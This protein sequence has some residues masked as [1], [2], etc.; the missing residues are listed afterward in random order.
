MPD[1]PPAAVESPQV[2]CAAV[3]QVVWSPEFA[4]FVTHVCDAH[5]VAAADE[6]ATKPAP[7]LESVTDAHVCEQHSAS[8]HTG[9]LQSVPGNG[10]VGAVPGVLHDP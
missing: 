4:V 9:A 7:Q 1:P 5:A 2:A 3:Q 6:S 10:F 8:V